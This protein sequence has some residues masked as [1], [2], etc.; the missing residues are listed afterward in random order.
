MRVACDRSVELERR[1]AER[2]SVTRHDELVVEPRRPQ[3]FECDRAHD[4]HDH[5]G[6]GQL[7][8][9]ETARAQPLGTRALEKTQVVR[10]VDDAGGIGVFAVDA[11]T[12]AEGLRSRELHPFPNADDH[13]SRKR[14]SRSNAG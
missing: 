14:A 4:E 11:Q 6:A 2:A 7:L 3:K 5:R 10:V 12:E 9:V 1:R 8:L 13:G